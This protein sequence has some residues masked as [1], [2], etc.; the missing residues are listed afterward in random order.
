MKTHC[1]RGS[2]STSDAHTDLRSFPTHWILWGHRGS[3]AGE[4]SGEQAGDTGEV[5]VVYVPRCS[6]VSPSTVLLIT[7]PHSSPISRFC[8]LL[9]ALHI[10]N[11]GIE[12]LDN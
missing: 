10:G 11:G 3:T 1:L 9:L 6:I 4:L 12:Q 5:A 8:D 2:H 7:N